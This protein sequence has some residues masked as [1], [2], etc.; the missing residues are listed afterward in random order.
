MVGAGETAAA[1]GATGL[2]ACRELALEPDAAGEGV[3]LAA[4]GAAAGALA[5]GLALLRVREV[6]LAIARVGRGWRRKG[7]ES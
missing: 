6:R 4:V 7:A 3:E 5:A 2:V 1:G